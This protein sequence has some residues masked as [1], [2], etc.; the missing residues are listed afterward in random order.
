MSKSNDEITKSWAKKVVEELP[1]GAPINNLFAF[2][3]T[4]REGDYNHTRLVKPDKGAKKIGTITLAGYKM[5]DMGH[6]SYPF[7]IKT[8]NEKDTIVVELHELKDELLINRIHGMEIGAGYGV[9]K[10]ENKGKTYWLYVHPNE[11]DY[12]GYRE[13]TGGD[14]MQYKKRLNGY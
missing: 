3:G 2:Y 10:I 12:K 7:A 6:G 4:L 8:G 14:W 1:H 5:Y 9:E 13:V 11:R